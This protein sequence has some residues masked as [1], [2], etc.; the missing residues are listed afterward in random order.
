MLSEPSVPGYAEQRAGAA[1]NVPLWTR[2]KGND[3]EDETLYT[4]DRLVGKTSADLSVFAIP[5][6]SGTIFRH[7]SVIDVTVNQGYVIVMRRPGRTPSP[8]P[9]AETPRLF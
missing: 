6:G 2:K 5:L 1:W 7:A 9:E 8:R 4:L 3:K